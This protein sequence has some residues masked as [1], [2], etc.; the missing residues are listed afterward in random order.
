[1]FQIGAKVVVTKI[2]TCFYTSGFR[3]VRFLNIKHYG[4]KMD[5]M[6]VGLHTNKKQVKKYQKKGLQKPETPDIC[7]IRL[8]YNC[9]CECQSEY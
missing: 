7:R 1:V 2:F 4:M 9:Q 3:F 8:K 5:V 6:Y